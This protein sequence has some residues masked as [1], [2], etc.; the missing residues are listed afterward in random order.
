MTMTKPV[1]AYFGNYPPLYTRVRTTLKGL[2][3]NNI[4]VIECRHD[5]PWL[6]LRLL[7]LAFKYLRI[8]RKVDVLM[9]AEGGQAHVPLAKILAKLTK[10][11]LLFDAFLSYY[12]VK[13]ID[14]KV[15][16]PNS[17]KGYYYYYL[18]KLSCALAD[19]VLLDTDEHIKYFC[20]TFA[21]PKLQFR[22]LPVGSDEE[23]FYPRQN[24][25]GPQDKSF[26]IFLVTSFYPLHGVEYVVK[27]AKILE[28]YP[29][30]QFIVVGNGS[31][32]AEVQRLAGSLHLKNIKFRDGVPPYQL[33]YLMAGADICLGQFGHTEHTQLVVPAKVYDA[34]AM[35]KPIITGRTRAVESSFIDRE[36][37]ILC[38]VADPNALAHAILL[39]KNNPALRKKIAK[40]GYGL[41]KERFSL[42]KTGAQLKTILQELIKI[43]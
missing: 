20:R 25:D 27:A 12:H 24:D 7:I 43:S 6:W 11:P 38:P 17:L 28:S 13:V 4:Q 22:T 18:D 16:K 19:L 21:L 29:D 35:A 40:N 31:T 39:L 8:A 1:V 14:T 32:R 9:V 3:K 26:I 41:F 33:P 42:A 30:I 36:N 2:E 15:I 23:W 10:K 5:H 34:L 37:I